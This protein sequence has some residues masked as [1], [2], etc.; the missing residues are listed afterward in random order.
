MILRTVDVTVGFDH[1]SW[2]TLDF[3]FPGSET[4]IQKDVLKLNV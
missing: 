1:M 3:V 2:A 4:W